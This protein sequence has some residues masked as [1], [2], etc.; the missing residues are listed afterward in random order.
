MA[1]LF[2]IYMGTSERTSVE[3]I[4]IYRGQEALQLLLEGHALK[5]IRKADTWKLQIDGS[6]LVET[7]NIVEQRNAEYKNI[8]EHISKPKLQ[9]ALWLLLPIPV[10]V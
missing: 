5:M 8:Q 7:Q 4:A 2:R 3:V 6:M 9:V 1:H 10:S